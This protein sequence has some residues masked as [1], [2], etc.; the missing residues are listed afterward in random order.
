VNNS[1]ESLA[2]VFGYLFGERDWRLLF[3][4]LE[5]RQ[6]YLSFLST[7]SLRHIIIFEFDHFFRIFGNSKIYIRG[8]CV[9]QTG[10]LF[11]VYIGKGRGCS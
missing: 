1:F 3:C 5:S 7:E 2:M 11:Q 4:S 6:A 9:F 10:D 8:H